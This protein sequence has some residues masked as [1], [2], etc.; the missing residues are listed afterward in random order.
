MDKEP[1]KETLDE[2]I[3]ARPYEKVTKKGIEARI[4]STQYHLLP[5]T[6]VTICNLI[7]DNG[8]S[9]RGESACVDHLNYDRAIGEELAY[10]NAFNKIW[11]L[12][13][14]LLAERRF[15]ARTEK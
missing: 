3:A 5:D 6:S 15:S 2:R 4:Y 8:F 7:L 1:A 10:K 11:E 13:G 14:Y 12:E 9:V